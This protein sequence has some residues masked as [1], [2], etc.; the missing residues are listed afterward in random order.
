MAEIYIKNG[1]V[2]PSIKLLIEI[3]ESNEFHFNSEELVDRKTN[4]SIKLN[5]DKATEE[6]NERSHLNEDIKKFLIRYRAC[7]NALN[8]SKR[9]RE[10]ISNYNFLTHVSKEHKKADDKPE[11]GGEQPQD[12]KH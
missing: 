7:A 2:K 11:M 8:E 9:F 1:E 10:I 12:D 3:A 5:F 4:E 6:I